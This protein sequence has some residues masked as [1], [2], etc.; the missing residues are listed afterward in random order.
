MELRHMRHFVAVAEELNFS[1]AAR[2]LN[3]A[4]PPL[5]QSIRRLE[6]ELEVT[7]FVR[8]GKGVELTKSGQVFLREARSCL[9]YGDLAQK[10]ARR[11]NELRPEVRVSFTV[12]AIHRL[13]PNL[14]VGYR[15]EF[16]DV[17]VHLFEKPS[18]AQIKPLLEGDC[19]VAF[20]SN[21]TRGMDAFETLIV[22]RA[23]LVAVIPAGWPLAEQPS[24]TLAELAEYPF[25]LPPEKEYTIGSDATLSLF[26]KA[27]VMP[28]VTQGVTHA[29]T[30]LKL[31]GAGLGCT[32]TTETARS[33]SPDLAFVPLNE[34]ENTQE[35]SLMMAWMP[36]QINDAAKSFV[37]FV[38]TYVQTNEASGHWANDHWAKE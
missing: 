5:S 34:S 25:I 27:G 38:E 29:S 4:Q 11:E 2:R 32:L 21:H 6:D 17:G 19:D 13:L 8:T 16:P 15:D 3:M 7:L 35:W 12:A 10:L 31:V 14:L 1:R 26:R 37:R 30:T 23:R 24:V 22:E 28:Y 20:L 33:A 9:R 18:P 36:E